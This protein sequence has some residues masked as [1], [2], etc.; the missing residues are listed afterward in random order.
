MS[1]FEKYELFVQHRDSV[2]KTNKAKQ[3]FDTIIRF[4]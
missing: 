1:I 2:L 3:Y 4:K